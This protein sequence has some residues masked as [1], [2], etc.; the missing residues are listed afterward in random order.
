[1]I[2]LLGICDRN[3]RN[4]RSPWLGIPDR[5]TS[6]SAIALP[7]NTQLDFIE[8]KSERSVMPQDTGV[9]R[10]VVLDGLDF[11]SS[12]RVWEQTFGA[13]PPSSLSRV[14]L[15]RVLAYERQCR[16]HGGHSAAT[17]RILAAMVN[18]TPGNGAAA[19]AGSVSAGCAFYL[20]I[21]AESGTTARGGNSSDGPGSRISA[22]REAPYCRDRM[23][24]DCP[25]RHPVWPIAALQRRV[26]FSARLAGF[27]RGRCHQR[28]ARRAERASFSAFVS[29]PDFRVP[30]LRQIGWWAADRAVRR[31]KRGPPERP[32]I[33][34]GTTAA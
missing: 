9:G 18:G 23:A 16:T 13:A 28:R 10:N 26:R 14:F 5:L 24:P 19:P 33:E 21:R 20:F 32:R 29:N 27:G 15:R 2:A 6:E 1:M 34:A 3:P 17:R 7:R 8:H 31:R 25:I 11:A 30:R 22:K 4:Q 12:R